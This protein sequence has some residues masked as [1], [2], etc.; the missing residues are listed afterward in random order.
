MSKAMEQREWSLAEI[1]DGVLDYLDCTHEEQ[2]KY[3]HKLHDLLTAADNIL[4]W[5]AAY[6]VLVD[7]LHNAPKNNINAIRENDRISSVLRVADYGNTFHC[8]NELS[9]LA[10]K[11]VIRLSNKSKEVLRLYHEDL[12]AWRSKR[13]DLDHIGSQ[14][15]RSARNDT[16]KSVP[17]LGT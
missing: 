7:Y 17:R 13:N 9:E 15:D 4:A 6:P 5:C 2:S 3:K 8:L 1:L 11:E 12:Q 10:T 16:T 14:N